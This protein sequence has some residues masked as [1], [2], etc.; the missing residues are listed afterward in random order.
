MGTQNQADD[1]TTERAAKL[2]GSL[3]C[4][5]YREGYQD[6]EN[7]IAII[8]QALQTARQEALRE[9]ITI[10]S[11]AKT[12]TPQSVLAILKCL[13]RDNQPDRLAQEG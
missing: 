1:L 7:D 13:A 10:I 2:Y 4:T 9:A 8:A 11:Q 3:T 12:W 6:P 5:T